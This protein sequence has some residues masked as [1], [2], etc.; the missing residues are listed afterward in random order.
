MTG[1][2]GDN[3]I[4][5]S[6]T[7]QTEG[8]PFYNVD[9]NQV[10]FNTAGNYTVTA[11]VTD[12]SGE[13]ANDSVNI[14]VTPPLEINLNASTTF[15]SADQSISFV[16]VTTGGTGNNTYSFSVSPDSGF[17][18]NGN[19]LTFNTAGNYI[20]RVNVTDLSGEMANASV[21][22]TVTPP[23]NISL[24]PNRTFISADQCVSFNSNTAGGTGNNNFT[25]SVSPDVGVQ[26]GEGTLCFSVA[27][28]YTVFNNVTDLSG[29][30]ASANAVITVT[31]ALTTL[32][33]ANQTSVVIGQWVG[34][35][36][37]TNGGTGSNVYSYSVNP[38]SA[39]TFNG[40]KVSFSALGNY[41]V[42]LFV[43]DLSGEH[44][45]STVF[46]NVTNSVTE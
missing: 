21:N 34:L 22:V 27:G 43:T 26:E 30:F 29:E 2:T 10:C 8:Q 41:S 28:N 24:T 16:N 23:L 37:I 12:L 44:A 35:S 17:V 14:T 19:V 5:H 18:Q 40:N 15:I 25:F 31:P 36:N 33:I 1:G 6:V 7:P 42:T 45:N 39:F 20:V 11:N 4:S 9:T 38:N 46:L 3:Q 13:F 32:L